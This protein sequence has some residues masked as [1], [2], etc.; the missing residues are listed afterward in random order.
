MWACLFKQ[1]PGVLY[2]CIAS[3]FLQA[4][5]VGVGRSSYLLQVVCRAVDNSRSLSTVPR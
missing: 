1:Q 3:V 2:V 5:T 4:A